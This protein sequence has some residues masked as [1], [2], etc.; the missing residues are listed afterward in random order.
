MRHMR[1]CGCSVCRYALTVWRF[2]V[3]V[4]GRT[5]AKMQDVLQKKRDK[6]ETAE[7]EIKNLY[8]ALKR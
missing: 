5:F 8:D 6:L 7:Q 3:K 1:S 2:Q 4:N